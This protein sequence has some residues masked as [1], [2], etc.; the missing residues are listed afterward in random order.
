MRFTNEMRKPS[1]YHHSVRNS[2]TKL[3]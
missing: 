2:R 3:C 1:P